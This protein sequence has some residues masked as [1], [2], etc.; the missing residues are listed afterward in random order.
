MQRNEFI[1]SRTDFHLLYFARHV[2]YSEFRSF[3]SHFYFAAFYAIN[4]S[5]TWITRKRCHLYTSTSKV[6]PNLRTPVYLGW[7]FRRDV[8][9]ARCLLNVA[10][11]RHE[12]YRGIDW[13]WHAVPATRK[14]KCRG[15]LTLDHRFI[16]TSTLDCFSHRLSPLR[17]LRSHSHAARRQQ[18]R[19]R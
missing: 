19:Q 16:L 11:F 5:A 15:P 4:M 3:L 13:N 12:Y 17:P 1:K 6:L 9:I 10:P 14:L 2:I 18:I 8:E 7:L